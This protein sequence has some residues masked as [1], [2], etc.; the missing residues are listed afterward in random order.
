MLA[1]AQLQ[2]ENQAFK[3]QP[4]SQELSPHFNPVRF[5]TQNLRVSTRV[6]QADKKERWRGVHD[7]SVRPS[8]FAITR[9]KPDR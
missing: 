7:I 6:Q 4:G 9:Q 8:Q 5:R 2:I 1:N 3:A